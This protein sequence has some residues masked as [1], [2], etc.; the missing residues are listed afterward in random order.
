MIDS[1]LQSWMNVFNQVDVSH[2]H[3]ESRGPSHFKHF[4]EFQRVKFCMKEIPV[5]THAACLL[6]FYFIFFSK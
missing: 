4:S 3:T 1:D 6:F 2:T 5:M